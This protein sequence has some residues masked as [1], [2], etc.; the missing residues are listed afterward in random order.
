MSVEIQKSILELIF[1]HLKTEGFDV[2]F[3]SLKVGECKTKYVV[4]K[5]TGSSIHQTFSSD[6]DIYDIICYVPKNKYS[7]LESFVREVKNQ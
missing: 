5:S 4:V 3:P 2:Y 7:Q 1:D 6:V